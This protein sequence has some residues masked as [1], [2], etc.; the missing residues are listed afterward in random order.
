MRGRDPRAS[1]GMS[2]GRLRSALCSRHARVHEDDAEQRVPVERPTRGEDLGLARHAHA[3]DDRRRVDGGHGACEL[4][5]ALD[6]GEIDDD[7][8]EFAPARLDHGR[9]IWTRPAASLGPHRHEKTHALAHLVKLPCRAI[10]GRRLGRWAEPSHAHDPLTGQLA[11]RHGKVQRD[12]VCGL[13]DRA[14]A[15]ATD[16][17]ITGR[18]EADHAPVRRSHRPRQL[19]DVG[20]K[21][22]GE[23]SEGRIAGRHIAIIARSASRLRRGGDA[24][25]TRRL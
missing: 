16:A 4:A 25:T 8:L 14:P 5:R 17:T 6:P 11:Q 2:A 3:G 7:V 20:T 24:V 1:L 9:E 19:D 12:R 22:I 23:H 18:D 13:A 10:F 21:G 15:P